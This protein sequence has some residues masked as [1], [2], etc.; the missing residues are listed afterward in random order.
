MTEE[1]K[2]EYD[3]VY[4]KIAENIASLSYSIRNKVGC[5]IVSEEGQLIAQGF[6]GTPSGYDNCCEIPSCSCKYVRG[7]A[8]TEKP[9]KEQM[10]VEFCANVLKPL[11]HAND[12][13]GYPCQYL[14]LTTK[15]EVLHAESNAISKCAKYYSSTKNSTLYVTLSPCIDCVKSIIQAGIKRVVFKDLYRVTDG[16]ELLKKSNIEVE[17]LIFNGEEVKIKSFN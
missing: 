8:V 4:M 14:T 10:S 3:K 1:R 16:L 7:C 5:I 6:N 13:K 15:P 2:L 12:K 9:I 17:Q 11:G